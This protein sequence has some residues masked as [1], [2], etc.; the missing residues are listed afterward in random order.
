MI[1]KW[2]V[3]RVSF[4]QQIPQYISL[5]SKDIF[6]KNK[7]SHKNPLKSLIIFS[8]HFNF[9]NFFFTFCLNL[10]PNKISTFNQLM[11]PLSHFLVYKF[12]IFFLAIFLVTKPGYLSK[13]VF[14]QS[15]FCRLHSFCHLASSFVPYIDC[16]T[17]R[18]NQVQIEFLVRIFIRSTYVS[19]R[20]HTS[21][22]LSLFLQCCH[23]KSLACIP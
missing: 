4:Q 6:L 22:W 1:L 23:G 8:Y 19:I 11:C 3:D 9:S 17:C 20:R 14:P 5:K 18:L 7:N 13:R 21:V 10:N 2:T 16:F 15:G 12:T